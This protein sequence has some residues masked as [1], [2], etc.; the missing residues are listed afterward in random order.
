MV[1]HFLSNQDLFECCLASSTIPYIT[2]RGAY[3]MFR[4]MRVIDGGLTNNTPVFRDGTRRQ[5]VFRLSQVERERERKEGRDEAGS[6]GQTL[7]FFHLGV[8][9]CC[10]SFCCAS[11]F[12]ADRVPVAPAHQPGGHLHRRTG[13]SRSAADVPLPVWGSRACHRLAGAEAGRGGLTGAGWLCFTPIFFTHDT[14]HLLCLTPPSPLSAVLRLQND[15]IRPGHNLRRVV[16]PAAAF[17][18]ICFRTSFLPFLVDWLAYASA[19]G[20]AVGNSLSVSFSD[21]DSAFQTHPLFYACGT[22]FAAVVSLLR[23]M[24]LLL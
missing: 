11:F 14:L 19:S 16:A 1:S 7:C 9:T 15:L 8:L 24:H 5:L 18:L 10:A 21:A 3:R 4:G 23:R 2:E 13:D 17:S 6:V 22:A 20:A 12:C